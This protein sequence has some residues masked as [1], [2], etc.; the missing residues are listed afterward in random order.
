MQLNLTGYIDTK[1]TYFAFYW[2]DKRACLSLLKL[3]KPMHFYAGCSMY[4]L[5][6]KEL[7]VYL[8]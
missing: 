4:F 7:W 5:E 6:I 2:R 1:Y 8:L 3:L